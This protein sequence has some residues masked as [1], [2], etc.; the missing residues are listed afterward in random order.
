LRDIAALPDGTLVL[1]TDS[2]QLMFLSVDRA[3]LV[4]NQR[5]PL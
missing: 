4:A 2:A 3:R 5:P 1:W